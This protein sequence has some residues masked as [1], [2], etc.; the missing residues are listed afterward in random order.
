MYKFMAPT[1]PQVHRLHRWDLEGIHPH[2]DQYWNTML[3]FGYVDCDDGLR[4]ITRL[5]W[6]AL[7]Y[8][9]EAGWIE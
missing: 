6:L 2:N 5:G 9:E 8:G 4:H 1:K 7:A 3:R